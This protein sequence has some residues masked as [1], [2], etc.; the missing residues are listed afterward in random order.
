MKYA[1]LT[2]T[3]SEVSASDLPRVGGKG[4]NLGV[5]ARGGIP[6]PPGFC[7]TTEAFDRFVRT[8]ADATAHFARL[9]ALD[10][11]SV[12]SARA[13]AEAMRRALHALPMPSDVEAAIIAGWQALG[14]G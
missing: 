3:F 6:V 8:L 2:L 1:A 14:T 9:D 5:L 13:A 4:A 7:V 11:S 12:D 10:G